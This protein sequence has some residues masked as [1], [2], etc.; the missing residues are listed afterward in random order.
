LATAASSL[1]VVVP[2]ASGSWAAWAAGATARVSVAAAATIKVRFKG[3]S[4]GRLTL[5]LTPYES[6]APIG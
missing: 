1:S 2:L 6:E 5:S 4:G 3:S